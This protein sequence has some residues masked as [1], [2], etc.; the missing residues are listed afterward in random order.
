M[1]LDTVWTAYRSRLRVFLNSR[2]SNPA[3]VEDLLQE[4]LI[5]THINMVDLR[6]ESSIKP[7]I[8]QIARRTVIDF[9]R[10]KQPVYDAKPEDLWISD[11]GSDDVRVELSKCLEPFV[12]SLP[13]EMSH[14]LRVIDLDGKS[15]KAYAEEQGI[16]YSTLKSRV[17][18]SRK[19]LRA[20]FNECCDFDLDQ[21]GNLLD[22]RPKADN[23]RD[24]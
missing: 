5:K 8:D 15:Q 13:D 20:V 4:I 22:F 14:L 19:A 24:C 10:K 9:Y 18:K 16:S 2:I 1:N 21:N 3:D 23:C 6:N 17:Q 7:W 11:A 12:A